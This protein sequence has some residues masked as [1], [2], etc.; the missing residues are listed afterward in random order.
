MPDPSKS[1]SSTIAG[2]GAPWTVLVPLVA[3]RTSSG[4]ACLAHGPRASKSTPGFQTSM[5]V[6]FSTARNAMSLCT[7][8]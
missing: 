6:Q 2:L 1:E 5:A 7:P 3:A 8:W 4:V